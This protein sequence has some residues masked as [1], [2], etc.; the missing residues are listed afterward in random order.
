LNLTSKLKDGVHRDV[1][2]PNKNK[3]GPWYSAWSGTNQVAGYWIDFGNIWYATVKG[4]G[5]MVPWFQPGAA[6]DMFSRFIAGTPLHTDP[7]LL[8]KK[9]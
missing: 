8:R 4:A 2:Q 5:H 1:K 3:W 9:I 6:Y 7:A